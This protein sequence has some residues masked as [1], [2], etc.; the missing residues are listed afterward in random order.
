MLLSCYQCK[1]LIY[2]NLFIVQPEYH[3]YVDGITHPSKAKKEFIFKLSKFLDC[4]FTSDAKKPSLEIFKPKQA[5]EA[6]AAF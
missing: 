3:F 2:V 6:V 4:Y 5:W 1:R